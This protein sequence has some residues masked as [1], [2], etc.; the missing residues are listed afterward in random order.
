[1]SWGN[2]RKFWFL[3][4]KIDSQNEAD[5]ECHM[6]VL[7]LILA[8]KNMQ[9]LKNVLVPPTLINDIVCR[10]IYIDVISASET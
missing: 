7:G 10:S 4:G 5:F 6:L 9:N 2:E 1:M 8:K 3:Q